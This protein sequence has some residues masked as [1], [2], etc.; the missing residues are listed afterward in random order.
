MEGRKRAISTRVKKLTVTRALTDNASTACP[1]I[2]A[3]LY[4]EC[5]VMS[6]SLFSRPAR[7]AAIALSAATLLG[8]TGCV[9]MDEYRR[10]EA[11]RKQALDQ[12]ALSEDHLRDM[13]AQLD[14]L[15]A[16][17][18]KANDV[19]HQGLG[20]AALRKEI[21]LLNGRLADLQT[22]YDELLKVAGTPNLPKD[23]T[24]A[25]RQLAD[26][27]P[28][29]MEWD[30]RLGLIRLKSDVTFDLGSTVVK[31]VA[32]DALKKLAVILD[33]QAIEANEIRIVGHTDD[34]PIRARAGSLNPTNWYLSTNRAHAV[35]EALQGDGVSDMRMEAA[36]W[37]ETRPIAPNAPGMKGNEQNRRVEIY[38][39][40]TH[41]P[42]N[43]VI[44]TPGAAGAAPRAP[45]TPV[46]PVAP[47][48]PAPTPDPA[49]P[50]PRPL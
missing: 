39:L 32:L 31:P 4:T 9:S 19:L 45:R 43:L 48:T 34:V 18:A 41:V 33:K 13:R 15:N 22:K 49:F 46:T 38:I 16:Q 50:A 17:L 36:G 8:T 40:P 21:D 23:I 14:A 12:L 24:D 5:K 7:I 47:R 6:L 30:E 20:D 28:E 27:N 35:R 11:A 44:S 10:S 3:V 25:L 42:E 29:L 1:L 26:S 37:G 2:K